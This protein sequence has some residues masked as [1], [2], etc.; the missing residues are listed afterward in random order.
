M[1]DFYLDKEEPQKSCLLAL[2]TSILNYSNELTETIKYGMPCFALGKKAVCYLW[3][4]K[5]TKEPY[6]LFV[7][8][9]MMQ[10]PKLESGDRKRM[11]IYRVDSSQD[12]NIDEI[13]EL[14]AEAIAFVNV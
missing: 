6:I 11:R 10:H 13:N 7:E 1:A 5:K 4:D 14:L 3:S 9:Q 2:R 8:G 12:L